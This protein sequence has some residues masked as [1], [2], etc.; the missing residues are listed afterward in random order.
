MSSPSFVDRDYL[1]MQDIALHGGLTAKNL[2]TL[3]FYT[4]QKTK[5]LDP[6]AWRPDA[7]SNC[8]LRLQL[9]CQAS[10]LSTLEI[11]V[12]RSEGRKGYIYT[13]TQKG[14]RAL[15]KHLGRDEK[16][17][18][19]RH[20]NK[21]SSRL[22]LEHLMWINNVRV[23]FTYAARVSEQLSTRPAEVTLWIDD[24]QLRRKHS[25]IKLNGESVIIPDGYSE[26]EVWEPG[27]S[28]PDVFAQHFEID[29]GTE[30][31]ISESSERKT[32]ERKVKQY[33]DFYGSGLFDKYYDAP[34]PRVLCI[35]TTKRRLASLK[36]ITE[37]VGAMT[38]FLF[39]TYEDIQ[40]VFTEKR[41]DQPPIYQTILTR[42]VWEKAS[43]QG[44]FSYWNLTDTPDVPPDPHTDGATAPVLPQ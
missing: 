15:A 36:H 16:E 33:L 14:A 13:L 41:A 18:Y 11:P 31:G 5:Q 9:L 6:A 19:W 29:R 22:F 42:P 28:E 39:S 4:N 40:A 20:L 35:T 17:L 34:T 8:Q 1:M 43:R 21:D 38:R 26:L 23:A 10:Y 7:Q 25:N 44:K 12:M 37:K 27:E 32:W 24:S 3:H 2:S 30:T